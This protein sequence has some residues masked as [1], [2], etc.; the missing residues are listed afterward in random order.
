MPSIETSD[1]LAL[2][3]RIDTLVTNPVM[4]RFEPGEIVTPTSD[5]AGPSPYI[6]LSDVPNDPVRIGLSSRGVSGVDHIRSGTLLITIQWPIARAATHT[7]LKEIAGRIAAHFPADQ[8]MNFGASRLRVTQDAA[9]L[10]PF[11]EGAYRVCVVRV[12]WSSL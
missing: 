3:S 5:S 10:Q 7:Q 2:K 8:C 6:L 12:V 9:V 11:V 1:W 4:A